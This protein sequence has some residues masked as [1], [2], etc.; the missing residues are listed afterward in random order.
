MEPPVYHDVIEC[1]YEQQEP[2]LTRKV[3]S[4]KNSNS[5]QNQLFTLLSWLQM[6]P[7]APTSHEHR[8]EQE[9]V[10]FYIKVRLRM[11]TL[12]SDT[13][14]EDYCL[15]ELLVLFFTCL[16]CRRA[17]WEREKNWTI[18]LS[19]SFYSLYHSISTKY[20]A[21]KGRHMIYERN[22]FERIKTGYI[23]HR[24][25]EA[26]CKNFTKVNTCSSCNLWIRTSV[27]WKIVTYSFKTWRALKYKSNWRIVFFEWTYNY[28]C[29]LCSVMLFVLRVS[30]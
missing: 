11:L 1:N 13:K 27:P 17:F 3:W 20:I 2:S 19:S 7:N 18:N 26:S 14:Y 28:L 22:T 12:E 6:L 9:H 16:T 4:R 25:I 5:L 8:N 15:Y 30:I 21:C 10:C 23:F 29:L 24:W